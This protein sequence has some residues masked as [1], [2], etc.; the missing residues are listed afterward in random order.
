MR[1]FLLFTTLISIVSSPVLA[2]TKPAPAPAAVPESTG[3]PAGRDL[4]SDRERAAAK[5]DE[6]FTTLKKERDPEEAQRVSQQIWVQWTVSGSASVD[7][8]MLWAKEAMDAKKFD[9][10][11]DFLDQVVTIAPDYPEGWNRR[12]TLHFMRE[13]YAKSM[14][15][16]EKTL[17][18]EPRHFGALSGMGM[19][20]KTLENKEMALKAFERLLDVYPMSRNAQQ[21]VTALTDELDG[22]GI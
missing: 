5:L 16:I 20:F 11:L 3:K 13:D 9:V 4:L 10:A 14:A 17:Q 1:A 15:D 22:E 21:E 18:L 6:L 8:M 2:Q 19:I 7:L 12:A